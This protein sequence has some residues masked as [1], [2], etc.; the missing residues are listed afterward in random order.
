MTVSRRTFVETGAALAAG[1]LLGPLPAFRKGQATRVV[2]VGGGAFGGWAAWYLLKAGMQVT[3][4][5]PWGPGN[6]R[7]SSSG[8][9]RIFRATYGLRVFTQLAARAL[10]LWQEHEKRWNR[11]LYVRTGSLRVKS[12]DDERLEQAA[13]PLLKEAG[14]TLEPL[15]LAD[16]ARRYPQVSFEGVKK[17]FFEREAGFLHA[18]EATRLVVEQFV[19]AGGTYRQVAALPGEK[20][21]G[22]LTGVTLSDGTTLTADHYVFACGAW[23]REIIPEVVGDL[24]RPT[25][26]EVFYFGTPEGDNRFNEP[27]MPVWV[28]SDKRVFYG[29]PGNRG[30]GFKVADDSRG[31]RFEPTTGDRLPTPEG[32]ANAREVLARR[33][34]ALKDA[35]LLEARV[36]QYENTQDGT[37]I[38]DRHPLA[39]N[40]WIVGGG[41]GHGF[42]HGPAVG[43]MVAGLVRGER[44][45]EPA[46]R[47]A[48][49]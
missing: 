11:T 46:F 3:L 14:L 20:T 23:L 1:G 15:S 2:V 33:F 48:R 37:F 45:A 4:L 24:I 42:K 9:T 40:M 21:A 41:S 36:C 31:P 30:Q 47:L 28:D 26:Q 29:I 10:T 25:R 12:V 27:Q 43:E 34:P 17:V 39:K 35:P 19:A 38:V 8:E 13:M 22:R 5:D 32:L 44:E 49:F 7:S 16:A 18:R 6:S